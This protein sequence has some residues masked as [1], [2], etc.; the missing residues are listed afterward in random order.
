MNTKVKLTILVIVTSLILFFA[1]TYV[2][3]EAGKTTQSKSYAYSYQLNQWKEDT[4][5]KFESLRKSGTYDNLDLSRGKKVVSPAFFL[6]I[7]E[8]QRH[9]K[10]IL[11][12][13]EFNSRVSFE[14]L[15]E[16]DRMNPKG[17]VHTDAPTEIKVKVEEFEKLLLKHDKVTE[18]LNTYLPELI[19][20]FEYKKEYSDSE[21]IELSVK[22]LELL[23][24][25]YSSDYLFLKRNTDV[26]KFIRDMGDNSYSMLYNYEKVL[27]GYNK[28]V[29]LEDSYK[30]VLLLILTLISFI[31]SI[32]IALIP[33]NET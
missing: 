15:R 30:K 13:Q 14:M 21:K 32:R 25:L 19:S 29:S 22:Q 12:T 33:E 23:S 11:R 27:S 4:Y 26:F 17:L 8:Y 31:F 3:T 7:H 6:D 28:Q 18:R 10:S 5:S 24:E 2:W 20:A 16:I 9:I 1:Q